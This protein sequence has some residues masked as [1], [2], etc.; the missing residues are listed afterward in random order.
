MKQRQRRQARLLVVLCVV[1]GT[2]LAV[3]PGATAAPEPIVSTAV[4][5]D[6]SPPVTLLAPSS[7]SGDRQ[8]LANNRAEFAPVTDADTG[9]AGDA[10]IQISVFAA[11]L[12]AGPLVSFEG[13][14]NQDNFA[15]VGFRV[16]PAD[17]VEDVGTNHYVEMVN[18]VFGVYDKSGNPL[19]APVDTG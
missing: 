3:A 6:V 4:A 10:A 19:L 8:R 13:V 17:P 16:N 9:Y 18:L 7:G 5:F 15:F 1:L 2:A 14:S 11:T 12:A